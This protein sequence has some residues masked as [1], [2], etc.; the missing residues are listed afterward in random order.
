MKTA[1]LLSGGIESTILAYEYKPDIAVTINYGQASADSEIK[2]SKYICAQLNIKHIILD[3]N[4]M[5]YFNKEFG[6][7]IPYRNQYLLTLAVMILTEYEVSELLIGTISTDKIHPD[8]TIEFIE[9]INQLLMI[10]KP[11]IKVNAPFI[12]LTSDELLEKTTIPIGLLSIVHSCTISSFPCNE[13]NS[14]KKYYD[15]FSKYKKKLGY[16]NGK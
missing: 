2:A 16:L 12:M 11:K 4:I 14:C 1:L 3:V 15:F 7:W 5:Q 6:E 10:D 8:G 9:S 13:C